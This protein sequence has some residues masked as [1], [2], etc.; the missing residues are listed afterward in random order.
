MS[1]PLLTTVVNEE[2]TRKMVKELRDADWSAI[3]SDGRHTVYGCSCGRHRI[4]V[5]DSHRMQSAGLVRKIRQ[6]I[7][8]CEKKM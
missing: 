8:T 3:R 2:S 1:I 7:T 6:A 5:P 4:A